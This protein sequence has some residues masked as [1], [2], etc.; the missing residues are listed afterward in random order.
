MKIKTKRNTLIKKKWPI[1]TAFV[2]IFKL[3]TTKRMGGY[4]YSTVHIE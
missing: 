3:Q 2:K 1:F 4:K